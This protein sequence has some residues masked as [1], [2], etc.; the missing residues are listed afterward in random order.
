MGKTRGTDSIVGD[1][2]VAQ[3]EEVQGR[4]LVDENKKKCLL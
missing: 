1:P 4:D 2:T 3:L